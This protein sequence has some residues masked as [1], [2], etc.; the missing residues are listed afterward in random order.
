MRIK[1]PVHPGRI[2]R[3]A[4]AYDPDLDAAAVAKSL[5]IP[6]QRLSDIMDGLEP[7][8]PAVAKGLESSL[9]STAEAWLRMQLWKPW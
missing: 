5:G 2:I 6:S 9:G 3:R 7:I 4:I 1:N 8:E